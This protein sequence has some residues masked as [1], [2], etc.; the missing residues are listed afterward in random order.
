[1]NVQRLGGLLV[2]GGRFLRQ[3]VGLEKSVGR[4]AANKVFIK[5]FENDGG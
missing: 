2:L 3:A 4:F 5:V 1:M